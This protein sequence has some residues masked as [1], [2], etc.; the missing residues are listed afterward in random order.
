VRRLSLRQQLLVGLLALGVSIG[1]VTVAASSNS[2]PAP[3]RPTITIATAAA[4]PPGLIK[5]QLGFGIAYGD[6]LTWKADGDLYTDRSGQ[7][8]Y[9]RV[10][11]TPPGQEPARFVLVPR[12]HE[13]DPATF[14]LMEDKVSVKQFT[15]FARDNGPTLVV[16]PRRAPEA[17]C[18]V[19]D[20][21]ANKCL[22]I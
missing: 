13:E 14:Y 18:R 7:K 5:G 3:V 19:W 15:A 8:W 1:T 2:P 4:A 21:N 10:V 6:T 11:V 17:G 12:E 16:E 22:R 20:P 9:K